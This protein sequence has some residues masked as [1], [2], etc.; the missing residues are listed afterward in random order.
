[1]AINFA[2]MQNFVQP[3]AAQYFIHYVI[4][5]YR[6]FFKKKHFFYLWQGFC[7]IKKSKI[8]LKILSKKFNPNEESTR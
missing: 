4:R 2:R 8:N 5:I 7:Y 6:V 1:M 3:S